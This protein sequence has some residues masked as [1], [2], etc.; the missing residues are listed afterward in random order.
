MG[1]EDSLLTLDADLVK[2][3]VPGIAEKLLVVQG[4]LVDCVGKGVIAR[5]QL[6]GVACGLRPRMGG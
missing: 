6:R 5:L 2:K 1:A 3:Q 4:R